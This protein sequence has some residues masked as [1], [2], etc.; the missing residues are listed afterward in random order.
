[1]SFGNWD[2]LRREARKLE[3]EL[4]LKLVSFSK[5]GASFAQSSLLREDGGLHVGGGTVQ[6]TSLF[7]SNTEHISNSMAVEIQLLLMKL[8]E[9]NESMG[10]VLGALEPGTSNYTHSST[11]LQQHR[12]KLHD[13]SQEFKKTKA[14]ITATREHAELLFSVRKD[15]SQYKNS[16]GANGRADQL[17]RERGALHTADRVADAILGQAAETREALTNQKSLL[18]GTLSKLS[19]FGGNFAAVNSLIGSIRRK[20]FRDSLILAVFIAL[21]ICFLLWYGMK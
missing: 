8:T 19:N 20:K 13:Y 14:T 4:E 10:R 6:D 2:E 7:L 18:Q 12:A 9:V 11:L 3:S 5:F 15:I 16:G 21:C 1:M 17:L